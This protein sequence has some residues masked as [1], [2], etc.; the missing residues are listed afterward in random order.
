MSV[1]EHVCTP[2]W[3]ERETVHKSCTNRAQGCA[4]LARACI[5]YAN[6]GTACTKQE[7]RA[8]S[9]P[10]ACTSRRALRALA[11]ALAA[12]GSLQ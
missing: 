11:S 4:R 6:K 2:M 7:C 9:V 3:G 12:G 5:C 8:Q 10:L 1:S